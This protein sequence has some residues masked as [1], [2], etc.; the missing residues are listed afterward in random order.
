MRPPKQETHWGQPYALSLIERLSTSQRF[1]WYK[2]GNRI[3]NCQL[4]LERF[5]NYNTES[6]SPRVQYLRF[7]YTHLYST[8]VIRV[9]AS[10]T[11]Q[12]FGGISSTCTEL[13]RLNTQL[14]LLLTSSC[15]D[16]FFELWTENIT[17]HHVM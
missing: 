1:K 9:T 6:L 14:V 13:S 5:I 4:L 10:L 16:T 2:P 17:M 11:L 8:H 3:F 7:L 15:T 12:L